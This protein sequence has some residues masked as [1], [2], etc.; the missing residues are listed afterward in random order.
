[1][2][3]ITSLTATWYE[4]LKRAYEIDSETYREAGKATGPT[5]TGFIEFGPGG[6]GK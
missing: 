2:L 5:A 4:A 3:N 1:M 6:S